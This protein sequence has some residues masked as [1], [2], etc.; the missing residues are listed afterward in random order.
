MSGKGS[1]RRPTQVDAATFQSNWDRIF[2]SDGVRVGAMPV[3]KIGDVGA[4][5]TTP[6]NSEDDESR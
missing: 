6:A 4:I 5:P 1:G 3:S 2:S